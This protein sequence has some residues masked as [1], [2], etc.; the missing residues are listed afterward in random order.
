MLFRSSSGRTSQL[1][2][3]C[4]SFHVG[5][6][7]GESSLDSQ[8]EHQPHSM[9]PDRAPRNLD[10]RS[11]LEVELDFEF[12]EEINMESPS[13]TENS[14]NSSSRSDNNNSYCSPKRFT[15]QLDETCQQLSSTSHA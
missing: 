13:G 5:A 15:L 10:T 2:S 12:S 9:S 3:V 14:T 6:N 11:E 7:D 1:S 8:Y 4:N